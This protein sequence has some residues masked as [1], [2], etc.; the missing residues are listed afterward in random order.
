MEGHY[1]FVRPNG[2]EFMV[3]VPRFQLTAPIIPLP[4]VAP[5]L[6]DEEGE[7]YGQMN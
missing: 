5:P 3:E 4:L 7:D 1:T 6:P 2:E